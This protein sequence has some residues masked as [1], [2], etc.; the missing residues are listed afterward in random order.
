MHLVL[1]LSFV[2]VLG[3]VLVG[4]VVLIVS[5]F[6]CS[7]EVMRCMGSGLGGGLVDGI[8]SHLIMR[9]VHSLMFVLHVTLVSCVFLVSLMML[10]H[11]GLVHLLTV[12]V[13]LLRE[14]I[15]SINYCSIVNVNSLSIGHVDSSIVL[16]GHSQT[17]FVLCLHLGL[18]LHECLDSSS[19]VGSSLF[20][21]ESFFHFL[22]FLHWVFVFV[23]QMLMRVLGVLVVSL[24]QSLR[25]VEPTL[26]EHFSVWLIASLLRCHIVCNGSYLIS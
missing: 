10:H 7:L 19:L 21:H 14:K 25:R 1:V 8:M 4:N 16:I 17:C 13:L 9:S 15:N 26:R 2:V 24:S 5:L 6:D 11:V 23:S 18:M 20:L 22:L 12:M 3:L